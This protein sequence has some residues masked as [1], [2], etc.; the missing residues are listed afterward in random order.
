MCLCGSTNLQHATAVYG[1]ISTILFAYYINL[2]SVMC[3]K[4]WTGLDL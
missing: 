2:I 1:R 4:I 3:E